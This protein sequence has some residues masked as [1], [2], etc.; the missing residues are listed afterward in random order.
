MSD[1]KVRGADTGRTFEAHLG[2]QI[3]IR[4]EEIAGTAY[5]WK[6]AVG[7]PSVVSYDESTDQ[8]SPPA[9][10]AIGGAGLRTM[11]FKAVGVGNTSI[12]MQLADRYAPNNVDKHFEVNVQVSDP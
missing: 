11:I 3:Q 5:S 12:R 8:F 4:L 6:V 7:N 2:D 9:S 10:G 1:I